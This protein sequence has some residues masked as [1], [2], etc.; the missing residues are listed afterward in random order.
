MFKIALLLVP[1]W[2]IYNDWPIY[3]ICSGY[4]DILVQYF[5]KSA[6][7]QF[8]ETGDQKVASSRLTELL[9]CVLEQDTLS[10]V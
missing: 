8:V 3:T 10:V 7:A 5:P 4:P 2:I 6:V 1:V 9:H